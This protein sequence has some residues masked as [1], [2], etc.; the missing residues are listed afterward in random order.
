[1]AMPSPLLIPSMDREG[2]PQPPPSVAPSLGL[3]PPPGPNPLA[4]RTLPPVPKSSGSP[5]D[6]ATP[7]MVTPHSVFRARG[8]EKPSQGGLG[9]D[10]INIHKLCSGAAGEVQESA[11]REVQHWNDSHEPTWPPQ[12]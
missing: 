12:P 6:W 5:E 3:K 1:M 10:S 4:A 11:E 2:L 9:T 7:A 8:C